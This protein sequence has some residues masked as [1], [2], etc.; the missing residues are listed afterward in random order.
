MLGL[1]YLLANQLEPPDLAE[2]RRWYQ[3]AADAGDPRAVYSLGALWA[4]QGDADN[5][6]R[7]WHVVI[8]E[9]KEND[10][11]AGAAMALAALSALQGDLQSAHELLD[12]A[13]DCGA[14][15]GGA[16]AAALDPDPLVRADGLRRLHDLTEDT[17]A[18]NFLGISAYTD[19]EIGQARSYWARASDLGDAAA[20]LLLHLTAEPSPLTET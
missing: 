17:N 20:P 12:L 7:A 18:L 9:R 4:A 13:S 19:R 2:A 15:S 6:A 3:K 11:V 14:V 10:L 16:C 5:A 8:E 1:G